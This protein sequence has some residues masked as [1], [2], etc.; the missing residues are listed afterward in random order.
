MV[1]GFD[2]ITASFLASLD[3][4]QQQIATAE[5]QISSGLR[6]AVPSDAPGQVVDILDIQSSLSQ[7]VQVQTNLGIVKARVDTGSATLQSA[8]QLLEN[9]L[10]LGAQG[11]NSSTSAADRAG[12]A[13]QL[14]TIQQQL[15][16][17]S[18]TNV[19]G[20]YIFS[21]DASQQPAYALDWTGGLNGVDRLSTSPNTQ[22]VL[23]AHGTRFSVGLTAGVIFD[24]RDSTD[25]PDANNVFSGIFNLA[26]ALSSNNQPAIDTSLAALRQA[27]DYLGQQLA[28]Y[29]RFQQQVNQAVTDAVQVHAAQQVQLGGARDADITAAAVS[30]AQSQTQ[31]QAALAAFSKLPRTSLFDFLG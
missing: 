30:L 6:I 14:Q 17:L 25:T 31:E 15:V 27:R 13:V 11:A 2:S 20:V 12:I 10:S 24:H 22:Q 7:S 3:I 29:G 4:T 9:A 5:N 1:N 26:Q 21:G 19:N 28:Q 8:E 16:S 18:Q 23:D